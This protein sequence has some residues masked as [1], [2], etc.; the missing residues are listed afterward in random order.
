MDVKLHQVYK[1]KKDIT[2]TILTN[3]VKMLTERG[4][5]KKTDLEE[6]INKLTRTISD[7]LSYKI[8]VNNE[9]EQTFAIKLIPQKIS[10]VSK[11]SVIGEFLN[12][13]K[14]NPKIVIVKDISKKAN[15]YINQNF[16]NTEIFNEE[17]LM[18]NLIDHEIVPKHEL[19]SKEELKDFYKKFNVKKKNM[20][21]LN[22]ND[23][24][25]R[26]YNMKKNDIV[27]ITRPSQTSGKVIS[28]RLVREG[29]QK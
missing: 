23:P 21:K 24:V 27:R 26:Y 15:Q 7:D 3:I 18:I 17:E 8:K 4:F 11:T 12:S 28:Y 10:S 13:Y 1:N 5:L 29:G 14:D 20:P 6:N 9:K 2:N 19:L 16:K 22:I 25:A